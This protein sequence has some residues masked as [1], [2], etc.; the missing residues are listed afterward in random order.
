MYACSNRHNLQGY[1][2]R[3]AV[4]GHEG[5]RLFETDG[6][7]VILLDLSMPVLDGRQALISTFQDLTY[8]HY[9]IRRHRTNQEDRGVKVGTEIPHPRSY[10]NVIS[11]RQAESVRGGRRRLVCIQQVI[12]YS[13]LMICMPSLV[14][15]VAFKTLSD[16]FCRLGIS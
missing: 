15:P 9:R 6:Q 7:F 10:R 2:Y 16:M 3:E 11:G 1:E 4:D 5:V 12:L 14:K 13:D 8:Q